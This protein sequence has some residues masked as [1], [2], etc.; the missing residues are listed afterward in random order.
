MVPENPNN[1][2]DATN[3]T[4]VNPDVNGILIRSVVSQAL[5]FLVLF[6]WL[7]QRRGGP[8]LRGLVLGFF[9]A[10]LEVCHCLIG[11][12]EPHSVLLPIYVACFG[13]NDK[14]F[15]LVTMF[16]ALFSITLYLFTFMEF[17]FIHV[18]VVVI[19]DCLNVAFTLVLLS[20]IVIVQL[21]GP[22]FR[23]MKDFVVSLSVF[24][25]GILGLRI[26]SCAFA[27][28]D[29]SIYLILAFIWYNEGR[30]RICKIFRNVYPPRRLSAREEPAGIELPSMSGLMSSD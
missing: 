23:L 4:T 1:M 10:L 18:L 25:S 19:I 5:G 22:E 20:K 26:F 17:F 6:L 2:T 27:L 9:F 11:T 3:S 30:D 14:L 16:S 13:S 8:L 21:P 28:N 7:S 29:P 12:V 15:V 24:A